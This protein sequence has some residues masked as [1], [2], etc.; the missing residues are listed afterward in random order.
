MGPGFYVE[1]LYYLTSILQDQP[2]QGGIS[3]VVCF[4][5]LLIL[6]EWNH[7]SQTCSN[8]LLQSEVFEPNPEVA[9]MMVSAKYFV[10]YKQ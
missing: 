5:L 7:G 1:F 8:C 4:P 9:Q 3:V 10:H 6:L 2:V